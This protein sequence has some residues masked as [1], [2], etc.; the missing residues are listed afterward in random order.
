M[1][2]GKKRAKANRSIKGIPSKKRRK[3]EGKTPLFSLHPQ[4]QKKGRAP[5]QEGECPDTSK[6]KGGVE[7]TTRHWLRL[8]YSSGGGVAERRST[9]KRIR[10]E[11]K[12]ETGREAEESTRQWKK[13]NKKLFG[14]FAASGSVFFF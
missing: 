14:L 4:A 12:S 3:W 7:K 8:N 5:R 9:T 10:R 2:K 13:G 11:G 6:K 1:G